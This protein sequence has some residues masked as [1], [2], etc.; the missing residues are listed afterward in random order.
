L[1]F[2]SAEYPKDPSDS[3]RSRSDAS[4]GR[5]AHSGAGSGSDSGHE[6]G[7]GN[8]EFHRE[9]RGPS[10]VAVAPFF[11]QVPSKWNDAEKWIAGRHVVHSN[12]IFAKKPTA[13]APPHALAGGNDRV[14][15]DSAAA[16][17]GGAASCDNGNPS[18][19]GRSA[20]TELSSKSSSPSSVRGQATRPP[21]PKRLRAAPASVSM[22]DVG[23]EM[24]PIASQEQSRSGTPAG[25]ATPSLSPLCSV[26]SS[27]RFGGALSSASAAS[28]SASEREQELR[29]RTRREIA[30]LGL[31]LGKMNIASWASKEEGLL[32]QVAASAAGVP[33]AAIDDELR[34][35]EFEA[36]AAKWEECHKSKLAARCGKHNHIFQHIMQNM[37]SGLAVIGISSLATC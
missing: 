3:S 25:A 18:S 1:A 10:P 4:H 21:P 14:A 20:V 22:R 2:R 34:T 11:R 28:F 9:A 29:L 30:A 24:T 12:P 6:H 32:A 31:Q 8:F 19:R 7:G 33:G 17:K 26:P 13:P 37:G 23:T 35:K 15:P 16:S 5:A 27:P 36:R